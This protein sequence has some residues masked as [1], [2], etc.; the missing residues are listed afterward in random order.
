MWARRVGVVL[1]LAGSACAGSSPSATT[2]ETSP[3][4][5]FDR[6]GVATVVVRDRDG[7]RRLDVWLAADDE[8]RQRGLMEVIDPDLEGRAGMAFWFDAPT[9][10]GFWMRNTRIPLTIVFVNDRNAV[11]SI[12]DMV[13]C[14][15]TASS[16]PVTRPTGTYQWAL[17]VPTDRWDEVVIDLTSTLVLEADDL[18][19]IGSS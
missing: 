19:A 5:M 11:V 2:V 10:G 3:P 13:P 9:R 15:D 17:E 1:I 12:A 8:Q 14:P 7:E 18:T 4:S 6:F 16:C